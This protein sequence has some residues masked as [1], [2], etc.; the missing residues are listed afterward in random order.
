MMDI[1]QAPRWVRGGAL[2]LRLSLD[3]F[4][5]ILLEMLLNHGSVMVLFSQLVGPLRVVTDLFGVIHKLAHGRR[6]FL[7]I[8]D[9]G[10]RAVLPQVGD[11]RLGIGAYRQDGASAVHAINDL[12]GKRKAGDEAVFEVKGL[13]V[14]RHIGLA[15]PL[16]QLAEGNGS[17]EKRMRTVVKAV[18]TAFLESGARV[19][20]QLGPYPV[21]VEGADG[22]GQL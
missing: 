10:R 3:H 19:Y 9:A 7:W 13:H 22:L 12:C 18:Y 21:S 1:S 2:G 16:G 5:E 15:V 4:T 8:T 6:Q 11:P 20:V 14:N 17:M